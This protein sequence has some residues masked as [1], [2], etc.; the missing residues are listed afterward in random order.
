MIVP[1]SDVIL[2]KVPLELNDLNQLTF[3]NATA[4]YNY[5]NGLSGKLNVGT[6]FTY[7]RKDGVMRVSA[8]IDDIMSYNYC[9]YRNDAYS[10]KWF[11]AF[12]EDMEYLNDNVTAVRLKTDVWQ[13]WQFDLTYKPTFVAREHTNDDTIGANTQP[14]SLET[15][16]PVINGEVLK[17]K[18]IADT[19]LNFYYVTFMVSDTYPLPY[20]MQSLD[21]NYNGIFSGYKLF[22]VKTFTE[23]TAVVNRYVHTTSSSGGGGSYADAIK[24]IFLVPATMYGL[25]P[26]EYVTDLGFTAYTPTNVNTPITINTLYAPR[27]TT[28]DGYTPKNK[29]LFTW[30]YSYVLESN[31]VGA[32]AEYRYED[33]TSASPAF[34]VN[35]IISSGCDIKCSPINYKNITAANQ[36]YGLKMGKLPVCSWNTDSYAIW[37]AQ[38]ELNM[39]VSL[40]RNTLKGLAGLATSNPELIGGAIGSYGGDLLNSLS[41]KYIAQHTP[42]EVHGDPNSSDYNFSSELFFEFR[43]MSVRAEYARVIDEYF[44]AVGYATNRVKIPN[45]TGRRNWNYV[46]TIGCYIEADIPQA[47]LNE[48]KSMFDKGITL[49]HNPATF[50][51][52]SQTN[53]IIST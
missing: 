17:Q 42:D 11:Y 47:D 28:I 37:M 7:Q 53:D 3:A 48:I 5:F 51:D 41:E 15:G 44:S 30:P 29:K 39:Q 4:Q 23:A 20:S 46:K 10:N 2:L 35:G 19:V 45:I 24:N 49:W 14:E 22:G 13:T 25:N 26:T 36:I 12:I 33:F 40:T 18:P 34:I 27:L 38:N 8:L 9:M 16:E 52:Y 1:Q 43:R 50:A 21:S 32:N 31:N 6:D